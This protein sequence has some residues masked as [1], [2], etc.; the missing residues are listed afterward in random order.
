MAKKQTPTEPEYGN[1]D[2]YQLTDEQVRQAVQVF[3]FDFLE[4]SDDDKAS[5]FLA[6]L[7]SFAFTTDNTRREEMLRAAESVLM[8]LTKACESALT[9][10]AINAHKRLIVERGTQ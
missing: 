2:S 8:P 1:Y 9:L 3:E 4:D 7:H 5:V 6:L 10:L